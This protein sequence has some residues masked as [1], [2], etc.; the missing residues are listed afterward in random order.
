MRGTTVRLALVLSILGSLAS[1][2]P[3]Q[4]DEASELV[5]GTKESPPFALRGT[6][7]RWSGISVELWREIASD[8]DLR[9]RFVERDVPGLLSGLDD[10]SLDASV[11]ALT[12]TAAR[13]R[14]IDFT[15]PFHTT[16]LGIA[17]SGRPE[18]GWVSIARRIASLEFLG[19]IGVR[20]DVNRALLERTSG[21]WWRDL[22]ARYLGPS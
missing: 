9:F 8:L 11:A 14:S 3:A 13:E 5:I 18:S 22:L 19:V 16:G 6:D 15:H 2:A 20:E 7:G 12:M 1:L 17:V 4:D 21:S 10:G